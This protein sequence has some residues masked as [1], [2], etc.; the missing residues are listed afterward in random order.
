MF[1]NHQI[2]K[3]RLEKIVVAAP[4]RSHRPGNADVES[5]ARTANQ[6]KLLWLL[7]GPQ[8]RRARLIIIERTS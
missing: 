4:F 2:S 6:L 5:Q 3:T 1:E 7:H 8:V